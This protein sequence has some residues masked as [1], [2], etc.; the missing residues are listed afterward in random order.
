MYP[1]K[2]DTQQTQQEEQSATTYIRAV[3]A[4]DSAISFTKFMSCR[5]KE[6][7]Q[8]ESQIIRR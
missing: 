7:R 2:K 8:N 5:N 1:D 3:A 4:R 6:Y